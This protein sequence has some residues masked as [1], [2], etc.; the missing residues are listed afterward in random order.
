MIEDF[1]AQLASELPGVTLALDIPADRENETW[2]L[3]VAH[4][5]NAMA[6]EW[7]PGISM[8]GVWPLSKRGTEPTEVVPIAVAAKRIRE[9][10][11]M[12]PAPHA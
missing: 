7:Q 12:P 8:L 5:G 3:D 4:E 9:L 6:L 10:L 11:A 2:W 1:R